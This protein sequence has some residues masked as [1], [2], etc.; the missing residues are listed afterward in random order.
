MP[1]RD[2]KTGRYITQNLSD[3]QDLAKGL[4]QPITVGVHYA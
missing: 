1:A 4:I 3:A 2:D